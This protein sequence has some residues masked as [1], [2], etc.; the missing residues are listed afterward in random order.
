MKTLKD[1][2]QDIFLPKPHLQRDREVL[3]DPFYRDYRPA[4][5]EAIEKKLIKVYPTTVDWVG[6][7]IK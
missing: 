3:K 1:L 4:M 5:T 6:E 2:Y 7:P